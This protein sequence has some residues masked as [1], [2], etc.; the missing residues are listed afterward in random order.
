MPCPSRPR[1]LSI[2]LQRGL[3]TGKPSPLNVLALLQSNIP[4]ELL[5]SHF[6]ERATHAVGPREV[7]LSNYLVEE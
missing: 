4:D 7:I 6:A 2:R 1:V 3:K 5:E